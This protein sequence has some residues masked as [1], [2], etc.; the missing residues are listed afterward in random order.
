MRRNMAWA[1]PVTGYPVLRTKP[2]L[3]TADI[4]RFLQRHER[5][6]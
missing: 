1:H 6:R 5:A 4:A 3:D 2:E